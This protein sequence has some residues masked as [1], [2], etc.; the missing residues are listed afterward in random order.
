MESKT[1]NTPSWMLIAK[2]L[3]LE[4]GNDSAKSVVTKVYPELAKELGKI[5]N[6]QTPVSLLAQ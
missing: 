4:V 2:A 1:Y 6:T 3:G 5:P